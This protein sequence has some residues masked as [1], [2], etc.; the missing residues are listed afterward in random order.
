MG[1]GSPCEKLVIRD[2]LPEDGMLKP[3]AEQE[4]WGRRVERLFQVAGTKAQV[5][6]LRGKTVCGMSSETI[7]QSRKAGGERGGKGGGEGRGLEQERRKYREDAGYVK[8][9]CDNISGRKDDLSGGER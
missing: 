7:V 4:Q 1:A 5:L 6:R 8:G 2:N 9:K 3:T